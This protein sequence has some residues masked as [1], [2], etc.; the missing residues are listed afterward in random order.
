MAYEI[1]ISY[2]REDEKLC[3]EL[4]AMLE[5]DLDY[6]G[7]VFVDRR[8]MAAGMSWRDQIMAV[9]GQQ[10]AI[11]PYVLLIAT[12]FAAADPNPDGIRA[13]LQT[14]A[15]QGLDIIAVEFDPGAA[16]ELLGSGEAHYIEARRSTRPRR[17]D[18]RRRLERLIPAISL[19]RTE[20][21]AA[22]VRRR[23]KPD[24]S[25]LIVDRAGLARKLLTSLNYRT[26]V[27]LD[28]YRVAAQSWSRMRCPRPGESFWEGAVSR[29][30]P[31]GQS[32]VLT[33][34]GGAGKSVLM[35]LYLRDLLAADP[36]AY[37][38]LVG[39]S[40]FQA[41][42]PALARELGA[43]HVNELPGHVQ[44]LARN[45]NQRIVFIVDGLDQIAV[46]GDPKHEGLADALMLMANSGQLIVGCRDGVWEHSFA[47]RVAVARQQVRKL[48]RAQIT[49]VL[50][51]YPHLRDLAGIELFKIPYFLNQV[52]RKAAVWEE[53]PTSDVK[54]LTRLLEDALSDRLT[55]NWRHR[56]TILRSLA[57]LQLAALSYD[58]PIDALRGKCNLPADLFDAALADLTDVDLVSSRPVRAWQPAGGST[59]RLN[60]DLIDSFNMSRFL[61]E[62][63]ERDQKLANLFE[64]CSRDCG[65]TVL[66][67]AVLLADDQNDGLL[68]R[69]MFAG[70]LAILDRKPMTEDGQMARAWAV[71][72][73]LQERVLLLLPLILE[74]LGGTSIDDLDP[75][76][77]STP[78]PLQ[79]AGARS[80]ADASGGEHDRSGLPRYPQRQSDPE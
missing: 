55:S 7:K 66:S 4:V 13:E 73:V 51:E 49:A 29:Y 26:K 18:Y 30:F 3:D 50:D 47:G 27:K 5:E 14:A 37:P 1:F 8:D 59:I 64:Q 21:T 61:I 69:K 24:T 23:P 80:P 53:I 35:A 65:W 38:V 58:I 74:C 36:S 9:L 70:I 31:P 56:R 28:N 46:P 10:D 25:D 75:R 68:Q 19:S 22:R 54:F 44:A 71:T 43:H 41:G 6:E 72:Y 39:G 78:Q 76:A 33:G 15:K 45:H 16:R 79:P 34:V 42:M 52:V 12:R 77:T 40:Q 62:D 67:M 60:H 48:D 17:G 63:D 2:L 11:K 20:V 57:Q 32:V